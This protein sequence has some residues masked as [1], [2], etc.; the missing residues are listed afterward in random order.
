MP[1]QTNGPVP[2]KD[3]AALFISV[4]SLVVS[5]SGVYLSKAGAKQAAS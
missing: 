4:L 3:K 2:R 1:N 5:V